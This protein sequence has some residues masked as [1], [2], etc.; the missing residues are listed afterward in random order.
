MW[1]TQNNTARGQ[2]ID[3]TL[4]QL[5]DKR[6]IT[7]VNRFFAGCSSIAQQFQYPVRRRQSVP[8]ASGIVVLA[9]QL[10]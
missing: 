9:S 5:H 8:N 7:S 10:V 2:S 3:L 4:V 6:L 1:A